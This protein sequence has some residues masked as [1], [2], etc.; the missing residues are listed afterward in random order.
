MSVTFSVESALSAERGMVLQKYWFYEEV[1]LLNTNN[2]LNS[3]SNWEDH[4]SSRKLLVKWQVK[5]ETC[6][7]DLDE[8]HGESGSGEFQCQASRAMR[9]SQG[10]RISDV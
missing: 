9:G 8:D 1:D 10:S 6:H 7:R 3:Q 2:D 4:R 5:G